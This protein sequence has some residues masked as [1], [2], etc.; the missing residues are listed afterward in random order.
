MHT[1]IA[2]IMRKNVIR[3]VLNVFA[4]TSSNSFRSLPK[5]FNNLPIGT[6]LK[7]LDNPAYSNPFIILL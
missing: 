6:L 4:I 7:K 2:D 3:L 1:K 5:R